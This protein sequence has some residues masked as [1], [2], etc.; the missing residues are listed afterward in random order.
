MPIFKS[1]IQQVHIW[2]FNASSSGHYAP[3]PPY[4]LYAPPSQAKVLN[5][6]VKVCVFLFTLDVTVSKYFGGQTGIK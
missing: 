1:K 2:N 4:L 6:N 3:A 5:F